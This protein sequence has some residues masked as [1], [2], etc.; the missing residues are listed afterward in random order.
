[1]KEQAQII[2]VKRVQIIGLIA[3]S[4]IKQQKILASVKVPHICNS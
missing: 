2:L 1:M 3:A 4:K